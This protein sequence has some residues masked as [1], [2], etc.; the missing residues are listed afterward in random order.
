MRLHTSGSDGSTGGLPNSRMSAPAMKVLPSLTI[1]TAF[2]SASA[3]A[4]SMAANKPWRTA[5]LS[6]FTG[7]LLTVTTSTWPCRWVV[8]AGDAF[9]FAMHLSPSMFCFEATRILLE[10]AFFYNHNLD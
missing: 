2:A 10:W 9:S 8:T 6:A 3:S 4:C 7:G 5:A 1:S